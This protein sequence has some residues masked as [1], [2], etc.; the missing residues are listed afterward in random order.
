MTGTIFLGLAYSILQTIYAIRRIKN[1][2]YDGN[3]LFDFYGDKVI[4]YFLSVKQWIL[5]LDLVLVGIVFCFC[6]F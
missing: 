4:N 1:E 3:L 6:F 5:P 2:N